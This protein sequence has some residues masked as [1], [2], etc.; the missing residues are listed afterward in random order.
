MPSVSIDNEIFAQMAQ[1][2]E[3]LGCTVPEYLA[4]LLKAEANAESNAQANEQFYR[5]LFMTNPAVK[6]IID[7]STGRILDANPSA[8]EFYQYSR[9]TLMTLRFQ[10]LSAV[11]DANI[12]AEMDK[13]LR[14]KRLYSSAVHRLANGALCNVELYWS[15]VTLHEKRCLYA[16]IIDVSSRKLLEQAHYDSERRYQS[17][18]SAMSEGVVLHRQD[19]TI[20][21]CNAAAERILGLSAAQLM[22]RS[23]L[24]PR[25]RAV[26]EDGSPFPGETHPAMVTLRT[27][28][29]LSNVIM[30]VHRVDETLRWISINSRPL[31]RHNEKMPY[32]VVA[33]FTDITEQ[34]LAEDALRINEARLRTLADRQTAFV[35]RTDLH[36]R[37]TYVSRSYYHFLGLDSDSVQTLIGQLSVVFVYPDDHESVYTTIR[38]CLA[39]PGVPFTVVLRKV[40]GEG[41]LAWTIWEFVAV[42]DA[43]GVPSEIQCIGFD[44]TAQ[45]V[46]EQERL[47]QTRLRAILHNER[48]FSALAQRAISALSH[49]A[50]IPLTVIANTKYLLE[51]Y[52]PQLNE[53]KRRE[54]YNSIDRQIVYMRA[55]LDDVVHLVRGSDVPLNLSPV[56]LPALCQLTL[57]ETVEMLGRDHQFSFHADPA[58]DTVLL[59]EPLISRVLINLLSNAVKFSPDG[60]QVRLELSRSEEWIVLKVIDQGIGMSQKDQAHIYESFFRSESVKHIRGTGLGLNIVKECVE[61]HQGRIHV[62]SELGAGTTFIVELPYQTP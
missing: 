17:I 39:E 59:D 54:Y 3:A 5:Q 55:L 44:I 9:D 56:N 58:I 7:P 22:G 19:G 25:W 11:A 48:Q 10:D 28:L 53:A 18:I 47:E 23:S 50:R 34:K 38:Q 43:A 29:P 12:F 45:K 30:G 32:G 42:Q 37:I 24:D 36:G 21:A 40:F 20:Q 6:L 49:D 61:R 13:V 14:E 52:S 46:A 60:S 57:T 33:T 51:H 4:R 15:E 35:I 26:H 27:G 31:V 8:A 16:I 41:Q 62:K 2:A 1:N